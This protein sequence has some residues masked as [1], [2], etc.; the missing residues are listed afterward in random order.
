MF[1]FLIAPLLSY[2]FILIAAAVIPALFLIVKI[3]RLDVLE[4][5]SPQ[6]LSRLVIAG[7]VSSLIALVLERLFYVVLDAFITP[8]SRLYDIVLYFVVVACVEEG[9]KYFMLKKTSWYS[10]EFNC[11]YDGVVYATAVSLGFA[12]WE[13]IS[14]VTHYG[15]SNAFV[16][17]F[18]AIP[19]HAS[20]GVFMGIFYSLAKRAELDGRNDAASTYK[21]MALAVPII[22]HGCYDYIASTSSDIYVFLIFVIAM[23]IVAY[24]SVIKVSRNDQYL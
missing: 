14:Y 5:E 13:N 8:G 10:P 4:Q 6:I 15:L 24:K 23:F 17:A 1:Y 18:T 7:I 2:N 16:R 22:M 3:Y 11:Q 19:G 20:F 9:S 12:L 21:F